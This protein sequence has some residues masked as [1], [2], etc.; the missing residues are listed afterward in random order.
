M[1]LL[2]IFSNSDAQAAANAQTQGYQQGYQQLAQLFGQ[3]AGALNQNYAAGLSPVM[4]NYNLA[5]GG[6]N[7]YADASGANGPEGFAR[8]VKNFQTSPGYQFALDQGNQNVLRNRAATGSLA[9]GGTNLDLLT[10][11]QGLANQQWNN[12]L[13]GLQPFLGMATTTGGQALSGY[14]D[15][16]S[17]LAALFG[18]QGNAAYGSSVGQGNAQAQADYANLNAS[19][20]L[21]NMFGNIA[22]GGAKLAGGGGG[23]LFG[24]FGGGR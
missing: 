23:S 19:Q 24:S 21:W 16:G 18:Q 6:A 2:D 4:Q 10:Y 8:A 15:L 11:G 5:S 3:G 14:G 13:G 7:A 17:R 9:S 22:S 20:N 1:G 12:W